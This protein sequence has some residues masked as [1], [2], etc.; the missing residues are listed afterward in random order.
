VTTQ[1]K[2]FLIP[3]LLFI[4]ACTA[5]TVLWPALV[6]VS[7]SPPFW[8]IVIVWYTL[9]RPSVSTLIITYIWGLIAISYSSMPLRVFFISLFVVHIVVV[10][11]R[12]RV[13][14]PG[15]RYFVSLVAAAYFVFS[16]S[17]LV[18]SH[19]LEQNPANFL[20]I[21]RFSQMFLILPFALI[22]YFLIRKFDVDEIYE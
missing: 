12:S 21:Q 22:F 4:L 18:A 13:Y 1:L 11:V 10:T 19:I 16:I 3:T 8:L 6:S 17:T 20:L 7:L 14:Q 2:D 15:P 9:R 5:Q